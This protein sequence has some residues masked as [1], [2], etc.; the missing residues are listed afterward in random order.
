MNTIGEKILVLGCCGSGKSTFAG[1]LRDISGLPLI[2]LD[3][4]WWK[5][6]RMHVTRD[7]FDR[8]LDEIIRTDRWIIDGDYR[9]TYEKRIAACD[10]IFFLDLPEEVC[11]DGIAQR[12]GQ[13]WADIPWTENTLDPE[14]AEQVLAYRTNYRPILYELFQKYDRQIIIFRTRAEADK[15]LTEHEV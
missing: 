5:P 3:N 6:D 8:R 14:L 11:M 1:K 9:R 10:T 13:K 7:E 12:V 4:I 15:W 2:H